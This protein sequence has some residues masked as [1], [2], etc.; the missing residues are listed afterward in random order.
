M[1]MIFNEATYKNL[2]ETGTQYVFNKKLQLLS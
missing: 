2:E 1:F